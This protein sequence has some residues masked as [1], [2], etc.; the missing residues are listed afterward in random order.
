MP[1]RSIMIVVAGLSLSVAAAQAQEQQLPTTL[2]K[3]ES[4]SIQVEWGVSGPPLTTD[5]KYGPIAEY[6]QRVV[7]GLATAGHAF[8][9]EKQDKDVL[10]FK[11]RP[12]V[13]QAMCDEMSGTATDM[14]CQ[15]IS[16]TEVEVRNP[17]PNVK[18]PG[19]IRIRNR[20]ADNRLM[21]ITKFS[22][23]SAG[24]IAYELSRDPKKKRPTA[25]C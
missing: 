1:L 4:C 5:R 22:E 16:E 25:R 10:T 19:T 13:V 17:D 7:A 20:C 18:L 23:Y 15:M 3:T 9:G 12:R 2:C 21:D 6:L 24:M 11:L 8:I 14:S